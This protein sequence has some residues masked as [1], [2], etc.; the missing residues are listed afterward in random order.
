MKTKSIRYL[1]SLAALSLA[2]FGVAGCTSSGGSNSADTTASIHELATDIAQGHTQLGLSVASLKDLLK[3]PQPDLRKQYATFSDNVN[4]LGKTAAKV[5]K[6]TQELSLKKD[7]FLTKWNAEL[8][9]IQDPSLRKKGAKRQAAIVE[10]FKDVAKQYDKVKA[11]FTPVMSK[12]RDIQTALGADL[13]T[14]GLKTVSSIAEDAEDD[15]SDLNKSF[16]KLIAKFKELGASLEP[17][18]P[19]PAK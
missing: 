11:D 16:D 14:N 5:E 10:D 12:L 8:D 4:T 6:T 17:V 19:P 18:T 9:K 15:A 13:T 1:G 7:A 3:N 2:L